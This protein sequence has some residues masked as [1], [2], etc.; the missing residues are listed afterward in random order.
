MHY[1][2]T[3]TSV[4]KKSHRAGFKDGIKQ[5][6]ITQARMKAVKKLSIA[7]CRAKP[8]VEN[9]LKFDDVAH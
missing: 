3:R 1:T 7:G 8:T 9:L 6:L 4:S 2:S 5:L